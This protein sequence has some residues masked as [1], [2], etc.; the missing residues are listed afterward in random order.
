MC[1]SLAE[2]A[3]T[4]AETLHSLVHACFPPSL[5]QK[6]AF[7]FDYRHSSTCVAE[8]CNQSLVTQAFFQGPLCSG[9]EVKMLLYAVRY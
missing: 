6:S 1:L 8:L 5:T 4:K 7:A 9:G 3:R 2:A